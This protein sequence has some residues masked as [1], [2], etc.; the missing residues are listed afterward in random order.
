MRE[1]FVEIE[2]GDKNNEDVVG[3]IEK[4]QRKLCGYAYGKPYGQIRLYL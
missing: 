4:M 3:M 2:M 1:R